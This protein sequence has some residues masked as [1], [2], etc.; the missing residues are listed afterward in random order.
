MTEEFRERW[1]GYFITSYKKGKK[2][3]C[4]SLVLCCLETCWVEMILNKEVISRHRFYTIKYR[5]SEDTCWKHVFHD[6][7]LKNKILD[8]ISRKNKLG[9]LLKWEFYWNLINANMSGMKR[10]ELRIVKKKWYNSTC[11]IKLNGESK[12]IEIWN[13]KRHWIVR[14]FALKKSVCFK[15]WVSLIAVQRHIISKLNTI[16]IYWLSKRRINRSISGK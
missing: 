9:I 7:P 4:R 16:R 14:S 15:W 3:L 2:K 6:F 5:F 12:R 8:L 10:C 1:H 11:E 13:S